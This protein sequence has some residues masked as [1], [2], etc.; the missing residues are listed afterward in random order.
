[1]PPLPALKV[2]VPRGF[3]AEEMDLTVHGLCAACSS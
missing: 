3:R 1:M 2:P